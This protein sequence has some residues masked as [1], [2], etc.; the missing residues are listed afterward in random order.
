MSTHST[1]T[2]HYATNSTRGIQ[3]TPL[4]ASKI[5]KAAVDLGRRKRDLGHG[6]DRSTEIVVHVRADRKHHGSV[7]I[8]VRVARTA[9]LRLQ[10]KHGLHSDGNYGSLLQTL[11]EQRA[12]SATR[13]PTLECDDDYDDP[14]TKGRNN[15]DY[16][17]PRATR[18]RAS[19]AGI[20]VSVSGSGAQMERRTL[21]LEERVGAIEREGT[22]D[23]ALSVEIQRDM[24][25]WGLSED[26]WTGK[27]G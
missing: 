12:R 16:D 20:G 8:A 14:R 21:R 17:D 11:A 22:A 24:D 4:S 5:R 3:R 7:A 15:R 23:R 18:R 2:R 1:D 6:L 19:Q 10:L 13:R 26:K 25:V 27:K 9:V